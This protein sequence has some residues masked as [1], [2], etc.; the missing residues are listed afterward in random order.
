MVVET[1]TERPILS[2]LART[3]KAQLRL[4]CTLESTKARRYS[5]RFMFAALLRCALG[6][7]LLLAVVSCGSSRPKTWTHGMDPD[8]TAILVNGKAVPPAN[9]PREVNVALTAGN[10]IVGKPYRR[11]S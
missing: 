5:R 6:A 11:L 8:K 3:E 4:T 7:T 2:K 9:L 1:T 10:R